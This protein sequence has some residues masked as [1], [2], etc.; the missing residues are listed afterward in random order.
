MIS[1]LI[2]PALSLS[3]AM[4]QVRHQ[5]KAITNCKR[6]YTSYFSYSYQLLLIN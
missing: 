4:A 3:E 5:L 1:Q 6:T 2:Y